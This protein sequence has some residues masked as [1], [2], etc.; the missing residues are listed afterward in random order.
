MPNTRPW[1]HGGT[2]CA[3]P[4]ACDPIMNLKKIGREGGRWGIEDYL[5]V[6]VISGWEEVL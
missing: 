5:E 1:V 3:M 6:K 4:L 2:R